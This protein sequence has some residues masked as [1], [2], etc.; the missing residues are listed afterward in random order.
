MISIF[1]KRQEEPGSS[2][3]TALVQKLTRKLISP[4]P[5]LLISE[6]A[7]KERY[8]SAE[9]ANESGRWKNKAYQ[10]LM[11]DVFNQVG[12]RMAVFMTSSQVG[13]TEIILNVIAYIIAYMTGSI[14]FMLPSES[15]AKDFSKA[16]VGPMIRDTPILSRKVAP[17][18]K[19]GNTVLM[20]TWPGGT[21]RFVGSNSADK[22][23][24]FPCKILLAD[25]ID[26][27]SLQARNSAG[28][29]EGTPLKVLFRRIANFPDG[30]ILLTS[31]P[32]VCGISQIEEYFNLSDQRYPH[33]PCQCG[34]MQFLSWEN[35]TWDGKND[36]KVKDD[37]STVRYQC[38]QCKEYFTD[39]T[40][41]IWLE[42]VK[43]IPRNPESKI[44]G[45]HLN[46]FYSPWTDWSEV[47]EEYLKC[48]S[49]PAKLMVFWNTFLGLPYSFEAISTPDWKLLFSRPK[50]YKRGK[51]P[52]EALVLTAACDV[53]GDRLE[54]T[55]VG[56]NRKQCYVIDHHIFEGNTHNIDD[57]CWEQLNDLLNTQWTHPSR[58]KK[59]TI[60]RLCIDSRWNQSRVGQF[61]KGKRKVVPV[62]G[63]D[64]WDCTVLPPRRLEVKRNGKYFRTGKKR[65]PIGSSLIKMDLYARLK[66]EPSEEENKQGVFPSEYIHFPDGLPEEYYRQLTGEVCEV[67][68]DSS[69]KSKYQW[70][71][72]YENVETLDTMVYNIGAYEISGILRW[73][74]DRWLEEEKRL[75][76]GKKIARII[77]VSEDDEVKHGETGSSFL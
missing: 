60:H 15:I 68:E 20:K 8:L 45:F 40:K 13:K 34:H 52:K 22:M 31:T 57:E 43:W 32:T 48:G 2:D 69:G 62:T 37:P 27:F 35:F 44:P 58:K 56:W 46:A 66:L 1:R 3:T 71:E 38:E 21:L 74:E 10:V 5:R 17:S 76:V 30:F 6:F 47:V 70:K 49:N 64:R 67:T 54:C 42:A 28:V 73:K 36:E 55:V 63:L 12:V 77:T 25:E 59:L 26:R 41:H 4:P 72:V 19:D 33:I 9:S 61:A 29:N 75:G 65:W 14:C 23:A 11:Q 24:S 50:A 16:R 39:A 53:Q 18:R 51:I 7:E